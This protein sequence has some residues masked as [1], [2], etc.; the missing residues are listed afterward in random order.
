MEYQRQYRVRLVRDTRPTPR[1]PT[2]AQQ[3]K[4]AQKKVE[5]NRDGHTHKKDAPDR[6]DR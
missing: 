6:G 1:Q 2:I 5:A 4:E 3:M